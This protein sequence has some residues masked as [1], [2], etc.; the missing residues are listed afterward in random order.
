MAE[1]FALKFKLSLDNKDEISNA[2]QKSER[3]AD[4]FSKKFNSAMAETGKQV[5]AFG[6]AAGKSLASLAL[7]NVGI[8]ATAKSVLNFR[9]SLN[10]LGVQAGLTDGELNSLR[11]QIHGVSKASNQMQDDVTEALDA[12]VAKTG[13]I[14][15]ARK[16]LELYAK[17]ATATGATLKD[18]A[19]VGVELSDKLGIKDQRN[20]L[21]ILA[22]QGRAGAVEIRDLATKAPKIF[23]AASSMFGVKGEEGLRGTG[24]LAQVFAK[25]FGGTGS[26]AMVATSMSNV[27][28]DLLKRQSIIE[29][30][31]IKVQGRDPYEVIKELIVR[32]NGDP[33]QLMRIGTHGV[34]GQISMR[35]INVMSQ[36]YK[37]TGGFGKFDE[38]KNLAGADIDA[39]LARRMSTGA[40]KLKA[41]QISVAASADKNLGDKFDALAG[42]A[43][44]LAKAF[45]WVT[46][47]VGMT[48]AGAVTGLA[49]W[50][51]GKAVVPALLTGTGG[52]GGLL[53]KVAGGALGV[54]KVWVMNPGFGGPGMPGGGAG[55]GLGAK[56]GV[57][58]AIAA[59]GLWAIDKWD[60]AGNE[61]LDAIE[62]AGAANQAHKNKV[63]NA[64]K[65]MRAQQLI[66]AGLDEGRARFAA[67]NERR[68]S[69]PVARAQALDMILIAKMTQAVK[70][71]MAQAKVKIDEDGT[72]SSNSAI[73]RGGGV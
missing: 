63:I 66:T 20:A 50:N 28:S 2:L 58:G 30:Q 5:A 39:D 64:A 22:A 7:G 21:S 67:E 69:D 12:F 18:V 33:Q 71:G 48:A 59:G 36:M 10:S 25:A 55:S 60:T 42:K 44:K 65:A 68:G 73:R 61:R 32:T 11:D 70:E 57:A 40:S 19:L 56:L 31:G 26:S 43:D 52:G 29:S 54:Q 41:A 16:N 4:S 53:S 23:S 37:Q 1:E 47:H 13:D 62:N 49:M 9:D 72:R 27:F 24:A 8:A 17:V 14:S 38:F 45:D 46:S 35:G 6:L 51:I 3:A 15:T 34:F